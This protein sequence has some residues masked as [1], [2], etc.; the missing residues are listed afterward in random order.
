MITIV[1]G[2][3]IVASRRFYSE[4]IDGFKKQGMEIINIDP[5]ELKSLIHGYAEKTLFG[6]TTVYT[7]QK[8][9]KTFARKKKDLNE[10]LEQLSDKDLTLIVWE[11]GISKRDSGITANILVKEF[12]P[13]KNIFKLLESCY[14]KNLKEFIYSL[15]EVRTKTNDFFVYLMLTR[16]IKKLLLY[17]HGIKPT[18]LASWQEA[19][20]YDQQKYW[21]KDKLLDFYSK[22]ILLDVLTKKGKTP[23]SVFSYI[24]SLS[25]YYL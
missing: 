14:P 19:K 2:E 9:L 23:Y 10:I 17:Q 15:S 21:S 12:K 24:E 11:D 6:S 18:N 8:L 25:V 16:H 7:T 1:C 3:D 22:L 20:L 4:K 13:E 5:M